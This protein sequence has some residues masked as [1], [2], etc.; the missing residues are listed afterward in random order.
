MDRFD[1]VRRAW[2]AEHQG[3]STVQ[4]RRAEQLGRRVRMRQR[5]RASAVPDPHDDTMLP[6]LRLVAHVARRLEFG[7][8]QA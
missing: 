6:P 4:R 7:D 1:E 3:C 2:I 8:E 5:R